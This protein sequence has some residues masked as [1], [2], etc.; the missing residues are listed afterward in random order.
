VIVGAL[1]PLSPLS[2]ALGFVP[3]PAGFFLFLVAAIAT[4]CWLKLRSAV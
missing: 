4:Y 1:L 3:L 2:K